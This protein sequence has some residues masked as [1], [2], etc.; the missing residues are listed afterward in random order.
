MRK[1]IITIRKLCNSLYTSFFILFVALALIAAVSV[2]IAM[3]NL[4]NAY[5]IR[6]YEGTLTHTAH[7]LEDNEAIFSNAQAI[8]AMKDRPDERYWELVGRLASTVES[9]GLASVYHRNLTGAG[10]FL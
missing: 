9:Y 7:F 1:I 6:A 4:F 2:G 8:Q 5:I 10:G 3:Y